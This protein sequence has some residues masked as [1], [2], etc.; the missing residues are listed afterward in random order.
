MRRSAL[1]FLATCALAALVLASTA[2]AAFDGSRA[3]Y[4]TAQIAALG[5]RPAGGT[6]EFQ[7]GTIVR[8]RLRALGY[9]VR[10]QWFTL[11]NGKRTRNVVGRTDGP[12][13]VIVVAHIDGVYG[14]HAANDNG[15][16]V[17]SILELARNLRGNNGV[18]IA[19]LA[20][21]ERMVTGSSWH[22]GS[23]RLTRTLS[24]ANRESVRLALSID[25][26]GVGTTLHVRGLEASPNRS[27]RILL[28]RARALGIRATYL[29][30][31]GQSDHDDLTRGGVPAA[32]VEWRWDPCW[33][34][35][36]DRI[37]RVSRWKLQRAGRVVLAAAR[38]VV[39]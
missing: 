6:H 36:C 27:A 7:A 21:E 10:E 26:V 33:H 14:T 13:K 16:G 4:W 3:R 18:L 37:G 25:M 1:G 19:G 24:D 9:W 5:Q 2:S 8:N 32:W 23:R 17:G 35:P 12:V 39:N 15:S 38:F 30:D 34:Q 11:P 29:R 22:L 20:A 28:G 31:T